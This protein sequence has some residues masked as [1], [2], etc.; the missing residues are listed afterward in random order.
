MRG[1]ETRKFETPRAHTKVRYKMTIIKKEHIAKLVQ[2][3]E[4]KIDESYITLYESNGFK[5]IAQYSSRYDDVHIAKVK[6][7]TLEQ[8]NKPCLD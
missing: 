2:L 8:F 1:F 6:T 5:E 3:F 4:N 7:E